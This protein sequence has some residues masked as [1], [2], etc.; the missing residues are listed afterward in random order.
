M[1]SWMRRFC[2]RIVTNVTNVR[3]VW[4]GWTSVGLDPLQPDFV[5]SLPPVE[6]YDRPIVECDV[7]PDLQPERLLQLAV[8]RHVFGAHSGLIVSKH[9]ISDGFLVD[10]LH[11]SCGRGDGHD[12]RV[13]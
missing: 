6:R 5:E 12:F 1:S 8:M 7:F 2:D 11:R 9:A 13:A 10:G 4:K 3:D